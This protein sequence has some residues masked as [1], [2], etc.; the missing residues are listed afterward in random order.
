MRL[1][2]QFV[3]IFCYQ[4]AIFIS[5]QG[6]RQQVP[7]GSA[8]AKL[9]KIPEPLQEPLPTVRQYTPP[10]LITNK[11]HKQEQH[12]GQASSFARFNQQH[13]ENWSTILSCT[14]NFSC[15]WKCLYFT[16]VWNSRSILQTTP[17]MKL[18]GLRSS[19]EGWFI[20]YWAIPLP[21]LQ[22]S[23]SFESQ[24]SHKRY[25]YISDNNQWQK[26]IILTL[27]KL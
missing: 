27:N 12:W 19:W 14:A 24:I 18:R 9:S 13:K 5:H 1:G 21:I 10:T 26:H 20:S 3:W 4:P 17:E 16:P 7:N 15:L 23:W 11:S 2:R 25:F 6:F 22:A 8:A